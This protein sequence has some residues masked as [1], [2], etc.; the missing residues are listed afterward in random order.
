MS[1]GWSGDERRKLVELTDEQI[2]IIAERAASRAVEKMTTEAYAAIGKGVV[3]K[4]M[5]LIGVVAIAAWMLLSSKG[6]I[7]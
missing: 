5:V 1:A 2:E 4:F 6:V 7:R 3:S